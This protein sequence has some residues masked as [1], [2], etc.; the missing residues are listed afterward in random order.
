MTTTFKIGK[1]LK[2]FLYLLQSLPLFKVVAVV[3]ITF[4]DWTLVLV[5]LPLI[6]TKFRL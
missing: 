3:I 1:L 5:A 4:W 2:R 6:E